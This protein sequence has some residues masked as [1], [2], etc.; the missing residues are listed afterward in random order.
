MLQHLGEVDVKI[1]N[2]FLLKWTWKI[3]RPQAIKNIM[4]Q[5]I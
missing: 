1:D 5:R 2:I 3:G 4:L